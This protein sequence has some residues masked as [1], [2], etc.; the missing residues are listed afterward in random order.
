MVVFVVLIEEVHTLRRG[1]QGAELG[2]QVILLARAFRAG[3]RDAQL[4]P[5][6]SP[7]GS[8]RCLEARAVELTIA[9]RIG[10][11]AHEHEGGDELG[12]ADRIR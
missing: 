11:A 5:A 7:L 4:V 10:A 1:I 2:E 6:R 9:R 3:D 8:K 12:V